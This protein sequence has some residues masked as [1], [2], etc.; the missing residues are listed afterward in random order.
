VVAFAERMTEV[1]EATL[2]TVVPTGMPGPDTPVPTTSPDTPA[3]RPDIVE[4][5]LIV[6]PVIEMVTGYVKV[7]D[8]LV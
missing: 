5:P 1:E 3:V 2:V 8:M 4:E 6:C 7:N